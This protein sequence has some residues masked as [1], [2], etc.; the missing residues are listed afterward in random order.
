VL[1]AMTAHPYLVAGRGRFDTDLMA[2]AGGRVVAKTGADGLLCLALRERGWGV[3]IKVEDG[4]SR[5]LPA[6]AAA[7][8]AQ[9]GAL[10]EGTLARFTALHSPLVRNDL[11]AVVGEQRPVFALS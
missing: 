2:L 7:L 1:D 3:A 11:G 4:S 5:G 9:L 8:L 6:I 10:D